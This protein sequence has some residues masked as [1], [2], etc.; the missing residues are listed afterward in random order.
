[1]KFSAENMMLAGSILLIASILASKTSFKLGIPT[2]ILFLAIGMLAGSEGIGNIYFDDPHLA[3]ILGKCKTDC[4]ARDFFINSWRIGD[5][6]RGRSFC[7][8]RYRLYPDG[9]FIAWINCFCHR[10]G[11]CFFYTPD[12]KCSVEGKPA[13]CVGTGKRKQ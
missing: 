5:S 4:M 1:M 11:C 8:S 2:L 12:K 9:R 3:E 7:A 13:P 6:Y 10:C